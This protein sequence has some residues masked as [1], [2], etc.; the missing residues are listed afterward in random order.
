MPPRW[1]RRVVL[2]P[3]VVA[4]SALAVLL[5]PV[6][7]LLAAVASPWIPGRWR[8]LR[9]L[10]FA[11]AY[12]AIESAALLAAFGIW[13]ASGFGLRMGSPRFLAANYA[14]LA[15]QLRLLVAVARRAFNLRIHGREPFAAE[16]PLPGPLVVLS[17]HAGPGDSFLL[18]NWLLNDEGRRPRIVLKDTMQWEPAIDVFLHRVPSRFI[19]PNPAHGQDVAAAIG[20]MAA[21]M[22]REDALVIFPEGGNFTARRRTRSIA[23]LEEK[24]LHAEA[25]QARAM[26]NVMAPRPRGTIAAIDAA[27]SAAAVFVAHTGLEELSAPVDL[28]R[29]L[30]MDSEVRAHAWLADRAQLPDSGEGL[31]RWLYA[32]WARI[33][34]WISAEKADPG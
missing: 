16:A 30:P 11:L 29:G 33:D 5:V 26:R 19:S 15:W 13:L 14:V 34:D 8:P 32:W 28:W 17:R 22:G 21:T 2:A 7:L 12:L 10:L 4:L 25:D 24:G 27:P 23:K 31:E 3:L 20:E 18:V 6:W 9:L 1:I